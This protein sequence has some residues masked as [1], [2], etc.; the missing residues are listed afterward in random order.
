MNKIRFAAFLVILSAMLYV[1]MYCDNTAEVWNRDMDVQLERD[2]NN[3]GIMDLKIEV[4]KRKGINVKIGDKTYEELFQCSISDFN[5]DGKKEALLVNLD[6]NKDEVQFLLYGIE[7]GKAKLFSSWKK[8]LNGNYLDISYILNLDINKNGLMEI[9]PV[10]KDKE[11]DLINRWYIL[12]VHQNKIKEVLGE[13]LQGYNIGQIKITDDGKIMKKPIKYNEEGEALSY[14][15]TY[16]AIENNIYSFKSMEGPF[17]YYSISEEE[18]DTLFK[19]ISAE[20]GVPY[21]IIRSIANTESRRKQ[22]VWG[23]PVISYD[24]GIGIMQVTPINDS[25]TIQYTGETFEQE[26]IERL[27]TD[28]E[29]NI[30]TGAKILYDKWLLS[31]RGVLP[32]VSDMNPDILENWYFA[33]MAYNGYAMQNLPSSDYIKAYQE[34]VFDQIE[35]FNKEYFNVEKLA[36]HGFDSDGLPARGKVYEL[37]EQLSIKQSTGYEIKSGDIAEVV[38]ESSKLRMTPNISLDNVIEKLS[39][40]NKLQIIE[41]GGIASGYRWYKVR[42]FD[43]DMEGYIAGVLLRKDYEEEELVQ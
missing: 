10:F 27:K 20:Q 16:F 40:G 5:G 3:D 30:R 33:V 8:P 17:K 29:F 7:E 42:L 25:I 11:S 28:V 1:P 24:G 31:F 4:T 6:K 9:M 15:K 34:K 18:T 26:D 36:A 21:E 38:I 43:K 13:G 39:M 35:T 23:E 2:L 37:G 14:T 12:E 41:D 19:K 22:F 32:K